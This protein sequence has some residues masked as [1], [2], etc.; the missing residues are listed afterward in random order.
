MDLDQA[1]RQALEAFPTSPQW[2]GEQRRKS[3]DA[4]L[5]AGF[6]TTH[7]ESWRYTRLDEYI[8]RSQQAL[9]RSK[10]RPNDWSALPAPALQEL[11]ART[12]AFADGLC[13]P[14]S[15]GLASGNSG[16]RA[17]PL[18]Q[19]PADGYPISES[20]QGDHPLTRLNAAFLDDAVWIEPESGCD[21]PAT[22]YLY[23]FE[24]GEP[25]QNHPRVI[26]TTPP[27]SRVDLIE[28]YAGSSPGLTNAVTEIQIGPGSHVNWYRLQ[29]SGA[30]AVHVSSTHVALSKDARFNGA[31]V[32]L[33]AALAR[34]DLHVRLNDTGAS[35][36]LRGLQVGSEA[37]HADSQ[38][39]IEH[40]APDTVSDT[41]Y[42]GI[43][44]DRA[45]GVFNGK[46]IVHEG[47]IHTDAQ[48]RND[49]LLLA[50]GAEINTKPELEIY[51]D[52]VKCSHGATTG[53]LSPQQLFYLRTRGIPDDLA[54]RMLIAAF[55]RTIVG[56]ITQPHVAGRVS[57]LLD[58]MGPT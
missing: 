13:V 20:I 27:N 36:R 3:L 41:A 12:I 45:R 30:H 52:D 48:L 4:F 55:A 21:T 50:P 10:P 32:D 7:S 38:L 28:H 6:P 37:H 53:Q 8:E 54:R 2:L 44:D 22:V 33:G 35:T 11:E 56:Q 49:N 34:H 14:G 43:L 58:Q 51:A 47:A 23:F 29:E 9:G 5:P 26:V 39:I 18:A 40:A 57:E 24:T 1:Y 17:T 42:R 16:V 15:P 46:I 19:W 25:T 31:T